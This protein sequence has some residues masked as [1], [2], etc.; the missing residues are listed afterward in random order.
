[1]S[2]SDDGPVARNDPRALAG[3]QRGNRQQAV[4]PDEIRGMK[5]RMLAIVA[6]EDP[7]KAGVE[8][9]EKLNPAVTVVVIAGAPHI[10]AGLR[11]EFVS[12]LRQFLI[13]QREH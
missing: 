3:V 6:S 2:S 13:A 7:L 8:N 10:G 5:M 11:P 9:F 4:T 1:M 12:T